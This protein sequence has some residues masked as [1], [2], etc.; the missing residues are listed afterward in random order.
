MIPDPPFNDQSGEHAGAVGASIN[1]DPVRSFLDG[2]GDRMAMDNDEAVIG[3]VEKERLT[4]PAQ[5]GLA[6]LL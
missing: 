2:A 6:L 4:D 5:V 3:L 1:P